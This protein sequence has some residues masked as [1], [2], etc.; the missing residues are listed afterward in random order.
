MHISPKYL[1]I[2]KIT[3]VSLF[4]L[5]LTV[6][7]I[8]FAKRDAILKSTVERIIIKAKRD[9][10]LN[11]KIKEVRFAGLKTVEFNDISVVPQDRD[12]LAYLS[13]FRVGVK[14]IPLL[15]GNVK[16]SELKI[17]NGRLTFVKRDSIRNYDFL[18]RKNETKSDEP[19]KVNL[20]ELANNLLNKLLNKI[21]DDMDIRNFEVSFRD[22]ADHVKFHA[23]TAT[24]DGG[25]LKS[26]IIVDNKE[27][28][29]HVQGT[30]NPDDKQMDLTLFADGKKV[31]LPFLERKFKLKLNFDKVHTQ[32]KT[33]ALHG[34]ELR[35]SGTWAIENMLIN[36]PKIAANDI[37]IPAGSID[38]DML[39]GENYISIDSSSVVH[40]KNIKANPYIKY[41]I[42]PSKIYELKLR[43]DEL[44]AQSLFESFPPGLFESLDGIKVAGKLQYSLDFYLDSA[45]PDSVQFDAGFKKKDFR[46]LGGGKINLQK[47]NGPFVFTPYEKGK[48]VRNILI[49]P[50]NPDYISLSEISPYLKNAVLT[51]E[52]PSF[53]SHRGFVM[54][55]FRGSIAEDFKTK[56]FKRGGSTISMQLV[57][58]VFLN[59]E[60]TI[61]RKIEEIMIVWMIENTHSSTKERMFEV[62]LNL[63]EWGR[64]VYGISEAARYYFDKSASQLSLGESI[65]LANIVPRPKSS[66]YFFEP[67]GSV[68][69]AL[70]DYFSFIGGTM[71][72]RGLISRDTTGSY[73]FY[74]V[75]LKAGLRRQLVP[76]DSISTQQL[77][78]DD[79]ML[80]ESIT[81]KELLSKKPKLDTINIKDLKNLK[82]IPK[83][84]VKTAADLRRERREDRRKARTTQ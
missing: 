38:A 14:L 15:F 45:Q 84:T 67:D 70:K 82:V 46:I 76:L 41:T 4:F 24:I 30:V 51:A 65:F 21:P 61:A 22:D 17:N 6:G 56:S 81:L 11:V 50:E 63:I 58:N 64:N 53:F 10:N 5:I 7:I 43:T 72:R 9:Y 68:R 57:K 44:D 19:S 40:L 12:S 75:R 1:K 66:L 69:Y 31:E 71:T 29:W 16:L 2:I 42:S 26:T 37:I 39:I 28:I 52:D 83:D 13:N 80:D 49:S 33:V 55:A 36:Q 20:A 62:Y 8:V 59:R 54:E 60:K 23:S 74:D 47:I 78:L 18:F 35:I 25:D 48:P 34:D 77:L 32:M 3:A 79:D 27:S 73:G